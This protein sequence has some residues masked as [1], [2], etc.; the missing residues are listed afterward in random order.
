MALSFTAVGTANRVASIIEPVTDI[1]IEHEKPLSLQFDIGVLQSA[2]VIE[3]LSE[4]DETVRI[5]LP[6][7]WD[8]REV[9]NVPIA[10]VTSDEPSFGFIRWELPARAGVS[11]RSPTNPGRLLLHNP[12]GVQL[13]AVARRADL[14]TGL[15]ESDAVLVLEGT[16]E[17]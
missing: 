4:S 3:I 2:S 11:F 8:L 7:S 5:S 16:G 15:V 12:S 1:G 10:K 6:A 9:R 17:L 14:E 13:K